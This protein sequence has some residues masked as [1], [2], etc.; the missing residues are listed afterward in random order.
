MSLWVVINWSWTILYWGWFASEV[1]LVVWTR[2]RKQSGHRLRDRGSLL[3]LWGTIAACMT[4][5]ITWCSTHLSNLPGEK[6]VYHIVAL[7]LIILGLSIRWWAILTLGKAFSVNVA[8]REGQRVM[9]TGLFSVVRHPSYLGMMIIFVATGLWW[10]NYISMAI[11]LVP[12]FV[13]LS[14]RIHVEEI[15]LREGFGEEYVEYSRRTK[16]LIPWI[17]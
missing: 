1:A 10:R 16:R 8:L 7:A 5:G 17:Y 11:I 4:L 3:V 12:I 6:H 13:A 9:K 15:A 14:Y 2:T